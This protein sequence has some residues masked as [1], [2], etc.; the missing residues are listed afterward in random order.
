MLTRLSRAFLRVF[1]ALVLVVVGLLAALFRRR[2]VPRASATTP[3]PASTKPAMPPVRRRGAAIALLALVLGIGLVLAVSDGDGALRRIVSRLQASL[4]EGPR[5]VAALSPTD[6]GIG[7]G[8]TSDAVAPVGSVGQGFATDPGTSGQGEP[9]FDTV[10]VEPNGEL[11]V[12]GQAPTN[13]TI[14]LLVDGKATAKVV[15]DANGWFAVVP[16]ALPAG[17]SEIGLRVTDGRGFVRQSRDSVAVAV[18]PSHDA[19]PLVALTSPDKPTVVL[20]QPGS[21]QAATRAVPDAKSPPR[22]MMGTASPHVLGSREAPSAAGASTAAVAKDASRSSRTGDGGDAGSGGTGQASSDGAKP[23]SSDTPV[24]PPSGKAVAEGSGDAA[25]K[26]VSVDVQEGGRLYVSGQAGAG[27]TVRFYLNDTLIASARV[28]RDG[29]VTFT[30]G[31]GVKPGAYKVRLDQVDTASGKVRSRVEVPFSVPEVARSTGTDGS[32]VAPSATSADK[33]EDGTMASNAQHPTTP[34]P[35]TALSQ[36]QG[37]G[38][39]AAN[40]PRNAIPGP[41]QELTSSGPARDP[42]GSVPEAAI[43]FVPE[44]RTARIERGDSLWAISRRTYGEGDRYTAIYD[45]NLDQIRD[46]DLIYP[47]QV[48]VL[49]SEDAIDAVQNGKRG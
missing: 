23:A 33:E 45:A 19:K 18:S 22:T 3:I 9:T 5:P 12:A 42:L 30:I 1:P 13:T 28:G 34:S 27:A 25:I 29:T 37:Q 47:G 4:G 6:V 31:R 46:P 21:S 16:P 20:S 11:V 41:P 36:G 49:P 32:R 10:R 44:V 43:V 39:G 8:N 24:S 38:A 14:E 48:F 2:G 15:A 35:A 40:G 17:N 26:I 7:R